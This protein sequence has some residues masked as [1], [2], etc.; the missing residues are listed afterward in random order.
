[1]RP[2]QKTFSKGDQAFARTPISIDKHPIIPRGTPCTI[3]GTFYDYS[4]IVRFDHPHCIA[5]GCRHGCIAEELA[6]TSPLD[7][8]AT[9]NP[10]MFKKNDFVTLIDDLITPDH[11][12]SKYAEGMVLY[13]QL[14]GSPSVFVHFTTSVPDGAAVRDWSRASPAIVYPLIQI[15]L[16]CPVDRLYIYKEQIEEVDND[17]TVNPSVTVSTPDVGFNLAVDFN[18]PTSMALHA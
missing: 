11:R 12:I 17:C 1:M 9:T 4:Y 16:W 15:R 7:D 8:A 10:R 2:K 13:D 3:V 18:N 6:Y 5:K 14:P